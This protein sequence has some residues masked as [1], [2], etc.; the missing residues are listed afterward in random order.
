MDCLDC[1]YYEGRDSETGEPICEA[2]GDCPYEENGTLAKE[3]SKI[4]IEIDL[5]D[6]ETR[7]KYAF[8]NSIAETV[9]Q[10]VEKLIKDEFKEQIR[11]KTDKLV[12]SMLEQKI[13]NFM[14]QDIRVGGGWNEPERTITR[15]QYIA[16]IIEKKLNGRFEKDA[17]SKKIE[18][19]V[20]YKISKFTKETSSQINNKISRMF[21]E[22]IR[23]SLTDSVV[24]LLMSNDTYQKLNANMRQLIGEAENG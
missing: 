16:E 21:D 7:I 3:D 1:K 20:S 2:A 6:M 4:K 23:T 18:D 17:L 19:E 14:D 5:A 10:N 12:D 8:R 13:S 24:S 9:N 15:N 22:S 11:D